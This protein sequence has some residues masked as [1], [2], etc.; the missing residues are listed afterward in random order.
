MRSRLRG[1]IVL[2]VGG[3]IAPAASAAESRFDLGFYSAYV[4]RGITLT[5]DP[6]FQPS[7]KLS[8]D[9]GFSFKV[10]GNVDLGDDNDTLGEISQ[11]DLTFEYAWNLDAFTIA[12]GLIEYSFPNTPFP[13]TREVYLRLGYSG[14]VSPRLQVYYDVD[15][16]EGGYANLAI[17]VAPGLS[18]F[19]RFAFEISAGAAD[20]N[21]AIGGQ[22]GL[23]DGNVKLGFDYVGD[24]VSVGIV[25]AYTESLDDE[26]L[27]EQP[28]QFWGGVYLGFTF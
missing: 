12:L 6:V 10:W 2:V 4:W 21:F 11:I 3:L 16:I 9:S 13:G 1:I 7:A 5:D 20:E 25:G 17:V 28:V 26:V 23:H 8:F 27:L 22:A 14:L 15:E 18:K 24:T 19:W